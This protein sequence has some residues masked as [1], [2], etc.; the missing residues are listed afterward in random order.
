MSSSPLHQVSFVEKGEA[1]HY[2]PTES[3][4]HGK[5]KEVDFC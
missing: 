2:V 5:P 4:R 1:V 3:S